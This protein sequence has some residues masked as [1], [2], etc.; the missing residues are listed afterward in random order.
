MCPVRV[1]YLVDRDILSS[2]LRSGTQP[3][4]T[5]YPNTSIISSNVVP[6]CLDAPIIISRT[7]HWTVAK[8]DT[9]VLFPGR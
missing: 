3:S 5:R 8:R 1:V 6:M 9:I 7:C 2:Q 4:A